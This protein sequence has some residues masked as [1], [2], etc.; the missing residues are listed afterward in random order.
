MPL[1]DP[2]LEGFRRFQQQYFSPDND[3]FAALALLT[4]DRF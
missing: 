3:L 4:N 2:L 1:A